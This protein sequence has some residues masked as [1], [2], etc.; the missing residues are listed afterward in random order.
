MSLSTNQAPSKRKATRDTCPGAR[1]TA[2]ATPLAG[3]SK[4]WS[5]WKYLIPNT[6]IL[7]RN[8]ISLNLLHYLCYVYLLVRTFF[9]IYEQLWR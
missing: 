5:L 2:R 1:E 7:F 4:S 6:N 3:K 9:E 8:Y